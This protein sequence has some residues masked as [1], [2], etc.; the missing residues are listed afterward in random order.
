MLAT[1]VV[2]VLAIRALGEAILV[3]DRRRLEPCS[4]IIVQ[5]GRRKSEN[6]FQLPHIGYADRICSVLFRELDNHRSVIA[7][8]VSGHVATHIMR[9]NCAFLR[10][11]R[12][13]SQTVYFEVI[14]TVLACSSKL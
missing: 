5:E 11:V 6:P 4:R 12:S 8:R 14:S 10:A 2:D 1:V 7:F 13:P 3:L 9:S